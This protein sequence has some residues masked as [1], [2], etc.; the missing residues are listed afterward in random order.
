MEQ[1]TIHLTASQASLLAG[2]ALPGPDTGSEWNELAFALPANAD[3]AYCKRKHP[4]VR[5]ALGEAAL[6]WEAN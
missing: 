6:V 3:K 2:R 1:L 4:K 5:D